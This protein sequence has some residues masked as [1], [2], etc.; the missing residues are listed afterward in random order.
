MLSHTVTRLYGG[1]RHPDR[2]A[3]DLTVREGEHFVPYPCWY[4]TFLHAGIFRRF[5]VRKKEIE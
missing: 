4:F 2:M 1:F 3:P 5:S